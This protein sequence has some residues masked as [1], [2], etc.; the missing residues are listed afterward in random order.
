MFVLKLS[1]SI[2]VKTSTAGF[3]GLKIDS[4]THTQLEWDMANYSSDTQHPAVLSTTDA[5][6]YEIF[7]YYSRLF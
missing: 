1:D 7:M 2:N 4:T 5:V 6:H 3:T